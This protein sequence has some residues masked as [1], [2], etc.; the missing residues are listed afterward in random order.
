MKSNSLSLMPKNSLWLLLLVSSLGYFVDTAD[1]VIASLVRGVSI[2]ELGLATDTAAIKAIGLNLET[3]Q[4]WG[5]LLGGV[6]CGV[7]GDKL[8]RLNVLYGSIALYSISTLLNGFLSPSWGDTYFYY[9]LFRFLS[10][11][12]LA[13]EMGIAITLVSE[14]MKAETRGLGS[15]AVAGFGILGCVVAAGLVIFA[16]LSWNYLFI[17]GGVSGLI[18]LMLRLGLYESEQF[19][20]Q[21]P[22]NVARGSFFSIFT[23]ADRFKRFIVCILIGLPTYYVVGLPIKFASNFGEA[24]SI[25]GV[26]VPIAMMTFYTAMSLSDVICNGVSQLIKSRKKMFYFYNVFNLLAILLFTYYPPSDAWQYHFIYCPILGASV[27]YWAL[28][29]TTTSETFGTNLRATAT[30]SVPNFIRSSF[31]PIAALFTMLEA[32]KEIGTINAGGF[33]GVICSITALFATY[34]LT[35]TFGKDLN[36]EEQ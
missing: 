25:K 5:I 27:G 21:K 23:N 6:C 36:F 9:C 2:K 18:L 15:M 30:T 29:V 4:S 10:G 1:L 24:L 35:E 26:S 17:F 32:N 33:I 20:T 14:V 31:I 8:G 13:A 16:N 3:W 28:I 7:L 11:F 12:G 19:K 22:T 34:F